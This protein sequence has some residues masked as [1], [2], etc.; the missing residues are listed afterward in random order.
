MFDE[1]VENFTFEIVEV[2][3]KEEQSEKEKYWIDFYKSKEYGY[4]S[5][6]GG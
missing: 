5:K 6:A 3:A 4:N 1:G 2:C